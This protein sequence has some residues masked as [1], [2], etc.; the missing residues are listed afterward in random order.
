[1][2]RLS[3]VLLLL[4]APLTSACRGK[5]EDQRGGSNLRFLEKTSTT[6]NQAGD[7]CAIPGARAGSSTSLRTVNVVDA[8]GRKI[9]P[10]AQ[11]LR[12]RK[13]RFPVDSVEPENYSGPDESSPVPGLEP[14]P[15]SSLPFKGKYHILLAPVLEG[16]Q[17]VV[18][19]ETRIIIASSDD[20]G[21]M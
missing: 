19:H 15:S 14:P 3:L 10:G 8:S 16:R 21:R 2:G 20:K 7:P 4:A 11:R 9:N 17:A 5:V 13:L 6:D 12:V 1:M 18:R